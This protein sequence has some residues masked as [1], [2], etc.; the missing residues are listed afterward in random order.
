MKPLLREPAW[1]QVGPE[2][3]LETDRSAV[4]AGVELSRSLL[5][6]T[7]S[8]PRGGVIPQNDYIWD[9]NPPT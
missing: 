9:S 3:L 1:E 6:I 5:L 8:R 2:N 7:D 4:S